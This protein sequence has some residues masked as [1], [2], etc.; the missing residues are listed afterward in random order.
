MKKRTPPPAGR[1]KLARRLESITYLT[2]D[3]LRKLFTV[4]KRKSKR[5][6]AIFLTAYRH[7]LRAS[8]VGL[9][10]RN[11]FDGKSSRLTI[12][13]LKGSLGGVQPMRADEVKALRAYLRTRKDDAPYLFISNRFLPLSRFMLW[14]L[15]QDYGEACKI[16][17]EKLKFHALKHSIATH[18]LDSA[19]DVADVKDWLGH[20]DIFNAAIYAKLTQNTRDE[21][22]RKIFESRKIV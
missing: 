6:Y 2:Q 7:G 11:D 9:L 16:A 22:I 3:E 1:G 12:R 20:A 13:R 21:R 18:M 8:E 17:P 19:G 4:I 10:R 15:M 5:D 14:R